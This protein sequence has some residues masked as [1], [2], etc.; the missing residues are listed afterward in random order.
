MNIMCVCV[1]NML[2][3]YADGRLA[4][5]QARWVERHLASCPACAGRAASMRRLV[6][7][8]RALP[9][10]PP[11]ADLAAL[12]RDAVVSDRVPA[13]PDPEL[14]H[15]PFPARTPSL[16]LAFGFLAFIFSLSSS[17]LGPG[18][19]GPVWAER[20]SQAGSFDPGK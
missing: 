10:P 1:E 15:E 11:P 19:P 17:L 2:D 8:L 13:G 5:C 18:I 7:A 4:A 12:I 14:Y 9:V 20:V 3:L 6:S 16:S